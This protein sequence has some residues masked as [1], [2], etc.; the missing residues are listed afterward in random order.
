MKIR[1]ELALLLVLM[2]LGAGAPVYAISDE[3]QP[4]RHGLTYGEWSARWWQ[5]V[6][7]IPNQRNPIKAEGQLNC[8]IWPSGPVF[9]LAGSA[10]PLTPPVVRECTVPQGKEIFYPLLNISFFNDP[11]DPPPFPFTLAEKQRL[12]DRLFSDVPD[13]VLFGFN[14]GACNLFSTVDGRSTVRDA[15]AI[16]RTQSPP[17]RYE[18]INNS[19]FPGTPGTVDNQAISDGFWVIAAPSQGQPYASLRGRSLRFDDQRTSSRF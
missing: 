10:P 5:W 9:F 4:T 16:A 17:F 2:V 11:A 14:A 13:P 1:A 3:G 8:R 12:L 18:V 15:I 6:I 7:S 19:V